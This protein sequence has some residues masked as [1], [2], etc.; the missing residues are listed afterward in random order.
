MIEN[1][2]EVSHDGSCVDDEGFVHQTVI[3][4]Y[5]RREGEFSGFSEAL[6][7]EKSFNQHPKTMWFFFCKEAVAV[8]SVGKNIMS[9]DHI[10]KSH[11]FV[12]VFIFSRK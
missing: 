7:K 6:W 3:R 11:F 8:S 4:I 12:S 10:A 9:V 5:G 2:F 1:T